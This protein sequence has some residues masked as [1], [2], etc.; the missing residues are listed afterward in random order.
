ME[1]LFLVFLIALALCCVQSVD[2]DDMEE[3]EKTCK[4]CVCFDKCDMWNNSFVPCAEW[5]G[6]NEC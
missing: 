2:D 3:P 4:N 5:K 1:M 6:E